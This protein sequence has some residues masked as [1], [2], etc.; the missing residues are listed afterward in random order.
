MLLFVL[1]LILIAAV[2]LILVVLA[3]NP[4]GEDYQASLEAQ[5]PAILLVLRKQATC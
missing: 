4:K 3:Q 5:E 2:L 1:I